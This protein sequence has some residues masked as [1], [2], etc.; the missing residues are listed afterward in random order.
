MKQQILKI[1]Q[2]NSFRLF[3]Q[4][5]ILPICSIFKIYLNPYRQYALNGHDSLLF[6]G[7]SFTADQT[8]IILGGFQ[9][10]SAKKWLERYDLKLIIV[11]PVSKY[12]NQLKRKFVNNPEVT[13]L[14]MA[15]GSRKGN[16]KIIVNGDRTSFFEKNGDIQEVVTLD[17]CSI[18]EMAESPIAFLEINIEG[19][20]YEVLARL[21]ETGQIRKIGRLFIQFHDVNSDSSI[22]REVIES[23]LALTHS[24]IFDYLWVWQYWEEISGSEFYDES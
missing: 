24:L 16:R 5:V 6:E 18:I 15:A 17:V 9:G 11:E 10:I 1:V 3:S 22:D 2:T 13:I 21:I 12:C 14:N 8:G 4:S 7:H 23:K 20:E 19:G